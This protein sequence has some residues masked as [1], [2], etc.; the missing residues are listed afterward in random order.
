M[1]STFELLSSLNW[2]VPILTYFCLCSLFFM[3]NQRGPFNILVIFCHS[4]LRTSKLLCS[5]TVKKQVFT[6][7]P[8]PNTIHYT[9][10]SVFPIFYFVSH[11]LASLLFLQ[12][13]IFGPATGP[14]HW[15]F[16]LSLNA[17]SSSASFYIY[18]TP[19]RHSQ[20]I[21]TKVKDFSLLLH[22]PSPSPYSFNITCFYS[23]LYNTLLYYGIAINPSLPA[24]LWALLSQRL[25]HLFPA[26]SPAPKRCL[27]TQSFSNSVLDVYQLSSLS[28]NYLFQITR[29]TEL[30]HGIFLMVLF[31]E[32]SCFACMYF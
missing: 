7:P 22:N 2:I 29:D 8:K 25:V 1:V 4:F 24:T 26:E 30:S 10:D 18:N 23:L 27:R 21:F 32:H 19:V 12:Y 3:H 9:S 17:L 31:Y 20:T 6:K 11:S 14:L 5:S 28:C 15:L 16:P 13:T